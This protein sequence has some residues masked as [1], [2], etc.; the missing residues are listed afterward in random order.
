M[1]IG[2]EL[3]TEEG[4][5]ELLL[6]PGAFVRIGNKSAIRMV[7]NELSHT[8]VELL[9]GTAIVDSE[10]PDSTK[11]VTLTYKEWSVRFRDQGVYRIDSD[12]PR[13]WVLE[14]QAD[15]F[16]NKSEGTVAVAQGLD[17]PFAQVLVPESSVD[18]PRDTLS[19]WADRRRQ[20]LAA[21]NA[22]A[23]N[24]QDPGSMDPGTSGLYQLYLLSGAWPSSN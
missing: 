19:H 15:V 16:A 7:D 13:L 21:D 9:A 10:D 22:I 1:D 8:R 6:T 3:H 11:S 23:A 4:R 12:P 24:T 2:G 20:S 5:A 17:V 18:P 14:G